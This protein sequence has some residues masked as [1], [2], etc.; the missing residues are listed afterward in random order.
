MD[1]QLIRDIQS[2][3]RRGP[4]AGVARGLLA[5]ASFPYAAAMRLR[6]WAYRRGVL[7]SR[8]AA[9]PVLSIGNVTVGGTGKTPM[10]AWVARQLMRI[11]RRPAVLL[12]GYKARGGKSD[13][14]E[15]L[16]ELLADRQHESAADSTKG[17]DTKARW[18]VPVIV[19]PNRLRG[20]EQAVGLG[21]DVI[22]LDDAFQHLRLR[23]NLDIVLID[24]TNPFGFGF[25]LP[26]GLLREGLSALR[27][28]DAVVITR[29]D[30]V[31]PPAIDA[32]RQK[33]AALAPA[34]SIHSAIHAPAHVVDQDGAKTPLAALAGCKVLAFCGVGNPESFFGA[35]ERAGVRLAGKCAFEDHAHY[36]PS[37]ISELNLAAE[38]AG[39]DVLL[40]TQ[41]DRVKLNP[42]DLAKPLWTLA[43]E[44][45]FTGGQDEL[46]ARIRRAIQGERPSAT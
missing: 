17:Q 29:S 28:A 11:G 6:R 39:A 13:E 44:I 5:V 34:A 37:R 3:Q 22:V 31:A 40:A 12:R 33:L 30:A 19:D 21:A 18:S 15:L 25:V 20:A 46:I 42:A 35:L 38:L 10:V 32:L 4:A 41:K 7:P 1:Q 26:R 23:R 14:A 2:G 24:A 36:D 16:L 43:V 9:I 27:Y 8:R 45:Q